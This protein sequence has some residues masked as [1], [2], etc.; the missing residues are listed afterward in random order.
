MFCNS[1][2][3]KINILEKEKNELLKEIEKLE[4][5]NQNLKQEIENLKLQKNSF[6]KDKNKLKIIYDMIA[7]NENNMEEIASNADDNIQRI[8]EMVKTNEEVK[9]EI[10]ELK[11]VFDKFLNEIEYLINFAANAKENISHLNDSV[12]NIAEVI[13]LI[14][15]IADQTNLLALNAAIE[16]A[17]AGEHGRG[18]AV[19]ADEV[20]KLAERTQK[21]TTEVEV[22][23]NLLKQNSSVMTEEGTKLDNI[24]DMMQGF[25]NDFKE[26]FEKLYEID[27][28]NYEEFKDLS[29]ALTAL[30]QKINN[31]LYKIK[32]YKEKLF[33]KSNFTSN[34]G[35]HGFNNWYEGAGKE[36]FENTKAYKE[37]PS[38]QKAFEQNMQ[39]VM[40][41]SMTNAFDE[42][43]KAE[44]ETKRMYKMLD[45]MVAEKNKTNK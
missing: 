3:G 24:I 45:D 38:S 19:V 25:M 32:N 41:G 27:L 15:E 34:T 39:D 44:K 22:N 5:E 36:S 17:R 8:I 4:K 2:K 7:Y 6:Q 1:Y 14:K 43:A 20:R 26:G 16:A 30:A 13:N 29:N 23:I 12:S 28:K 31:L 42:F 35:E 33:G 10:Q 18:F 37:I 40:K 9:E 21:A 11:N